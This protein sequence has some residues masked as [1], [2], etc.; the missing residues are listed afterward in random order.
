MV[1]YPPRPAQYGRSPTLDP[2]S[3]HNNLQISSDLRTMTQTAVSQGRPDHPHR[4]DAY[5][6][7]LCSESFSSGQHYWEVDVGSVAECCKVGV[8]YG[9]IARKGLNRKLKM[10]LRP[11]PKVCRKWPFSNFPRQNLNRISVGL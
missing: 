9:T 6:Q 11:K 5:T 3:A 7:A 10:Y 2:N 1:K 8:A 4:F